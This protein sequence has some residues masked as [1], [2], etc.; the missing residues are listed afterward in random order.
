MD[1]DYKPQIKKLALDL[2]HLLEDD[3]AVVLKRYGIFAD[4]AWLPVEKIPKAD[5]EVLHTR[6]RLEAAMQPNLERG[7]KRP[8]AAR[9]YVREASFT[10]LNRLLGLKV[11][12]VRD[13]F[14]ETI[15]TRPEYGGRS[16]YQRDF[17]AAHPEL[18]TAAD[19]ALPATLEAACRDIS[20]QIRFV[21]DV[22]SESSILWPRYAALKEAIQRIN[23]LP[24]EIW[25]EDEIIGWIY[26][27]YNTEEKKAIRKRGRPKLP[28]EVAVINQFFTPRWIVKYLVDNTLGRLW[29]EMHPDSQGVRTKCDYL[30]PEP[31]DVP[32]DGWEESKIQLDPDSPVNN[33]AA[34][35]RRES[36]RPQDI[37]LID[38]ACGTMHFGH[39]AFEVF[40]EIYRDA[41]E[42]GWVEA[43]DALE[44]KDIPISILK[45]NL[46][47]VDIDLRAVQLAALSLY[48]K[49]RTS[50]RAAGTD[51]L[52]AARLPWSV[53]LVC[54][55]ARLTDGGMRERFLSAYADDP[56]LVRAWKELF[57]EMEDIGQ[58]GSL[59]R[60]EERFRQIL[61]DY[62]PP[63]VSGLGQ[64]HQENLPGIPTPPRQM[65]FGET[66]GSN[67]WS[68][69]RTLGEMVNELHSFA[70]QALKEKDV[71]AKTFA[72]E[73]EKTLG[74]LDVFLQKYDVVVMNPPYGSTTNS[75][76]KFISQA[77]KISK[78]DL[79]LAFIERSIQL[80]HGNGYVGALTSKTFMTLQRAY[81]FRKGIL[82][83]FTNIIV[84]L[85]L[86]AGILDDAT[87]ETAAFV[88][89]TPRENRP[90]VFIDLRAHDEKQMQFETEINSKATYS[91]TYIQ[92]KQNFEKL[93]GLSILYYLP[94]IIQKILYSYAPLDLASYIRVYDRNTKKDQIAYVRQGLIPGNY[95]KFVRFRWEVSPNSIN[96]KWFNFAKGGEYRR[97]H[98]DIEYILLW[99]DNGRDIKQYAKEHYGSASRTIKNEEYFFRE[100]ITYP[101][102]SSRGFGARYL[103]KNVI[104]SDT[105]QAILLANENVDIFYLLSYL[106]SAFVYYLMDAIHPGR[107]HEVLHVSTL[108]FKFPSQSENSIIGGYSKEAYK[109]KYFWGRGDEISSTFDRPWLLKLKEIEKHLADNLVIQVK[110]SF[111]A[112]NSRGNSKTLQESNTTDLKTMLEELLYFE[113]EINNRLQSLQLQ[114][115]NAIYDHYQIPPKI[116]VKIEQTIINRPQEFVWS[117]ME[118]KSNKDKRREHVRRLLSFF[119]LKSLEE[120]NDGIIPITNMGGE[121]SLIDHIRDKLETEFSEQRAFQFEREIA[122]E[123]GKNIDD[124]LEGDFIQWHTKLYKKRPIIWH[125]SS[126]NR[127]FACLVYYHKLNRD[128]LLTVRTVYLWRL[129][130]SVR[131]RLKVASEKKEYTEI[132][133]LEEALAD[134][135]EFDQAL[136][137]VIDAGWDPDIDAGVKANILPLQEAGLLRYEVI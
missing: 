126:L 50:Q 89:E 135:E 69:R 93:P 133:K 35:P 23:A 45:H 121:L 30:V 4:R 120:D 61:R 82:F 20:Q 13:L 105:G 109:L 98:A 113:E 44:D 2:R 136:A 52:E 60:V 117:S 100:G 131:S 64:P 83:N 85:D 127:T 49:A 17:R 108:P 12:E 33:P 129:R 47:G 87:V 1:S 38:P 114:I 53:N 111:S 115:D 110:A 32:E 107:T 73:V 34:A 80:T 31:L 24:V 27:F 11:L 59:L 58:V 16:L 65:S 101:R 48:V 81:L 51:D 96:K 103:P 130:D 79:Y 6:Q 46:Y 70:R 97:Y 18:A 123:L 62:K 78:N 76:K 72:S 41:R 8:E 74:F 39:Y 26:Q 7:V 67:G 118:G 92:E 104:F 112:I 77:Y 91:H 84:L 128:T 134:I 68:P 21:F 86:G 116:R 75:A 43:E 102:I 14:P 94:D 124:W 19:D 40:Q 99:E 28:I 137:K 9:L 42:Q 66:S 132:N 54:A 122:K 71:N 37:R 88:L 15:Q 3:L 106:N 119:I 22:E 55:D 125:L 25:Q 36:K 90:S 29:L 95:D 56:V 5:D 10:F 63:T 57:R